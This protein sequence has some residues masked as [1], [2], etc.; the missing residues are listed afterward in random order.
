MGIE[1]VQRCSIALRNEASVEGISASV[2]VVPRLRD[3]K[4]S[5]GTASFLAGNDEGGDR[6]GN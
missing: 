1:A 2:N 5:R 4:R 6:G 3:K